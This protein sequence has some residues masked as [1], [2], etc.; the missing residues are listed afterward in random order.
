MP[1][2]PKCIL[3]GWPHSGQ[4]QAMREKHSRRWGP[5]GGRLFIAALLLGGVSL[6]SIPAPAAR[7]PAGGPSWRTLTDGI[8]LIVFD[9]PR[10]QAQQ[11][12]ALVVVRVDP[13][14]WRFRLI[15]AADYQMD[16]MTARQWAAL[17]DF[18]ITINAGMF[19]QD[20]KTHVGYLRCDYDHN[21][22]TNSYRSAAAFGAR[23]TDAPPF[24]IFDLDVTGLEQVLD[25][26]DCVMQNLRLIKRPGTNVWSPQ[27]REWSEVALGEDSSGR[28]LL[29]FCRVPF[30]M[31]AFNRLLLSLP[32]DLVAAQHL[33][34]GPEAQLY[35]KLPGFEREYVG[36]YET[37]FLPNDSNLSAWPIPNVLGVVATES[38]R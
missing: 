21:V 14:R 22:S 17:H 15:C 35:I 24:R 11:E 9:V 4:N 10:E 2:Y 31:H 23:R 34:G 27:D 16:S 38:S 6:F 5:A 12:S 25:R 3:A 32:L 13:Q 28:A 37:G 36:S 7:P 1:E 19:A 18:A 20:G 26:Y 30:A 8:D 29:I 33:E